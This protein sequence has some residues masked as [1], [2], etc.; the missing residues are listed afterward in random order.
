MLLFAAITIILAML[1]TTLWLV[2]T[3]GD[4]RAFLLS[5]SLLATLAIVFAVL[6]LSYFLQSYSL[7]SVLFTLLFWTGILIQTPVRKIILEPQ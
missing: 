5:L 1:V 6:M 4:K 3:Y 2:N 7:I